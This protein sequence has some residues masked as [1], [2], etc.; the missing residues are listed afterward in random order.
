MKAGE[1]ESSQ[2]HL[3][4]LDAPLREGKWTWGQT[5]QQSREGQAGILQR[6][7]FIVRFSFSSMRY[8]KLWCTIHSH[9]T[10]HSCQGGAGSWGLGTAIYRGMSLS[11]GCLRSAPPNLP[12]PQEA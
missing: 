5:E 9:R 4:L 12:G 2:G 8:Q 1:R 6:L 11:K 10:G 7:G 3:E